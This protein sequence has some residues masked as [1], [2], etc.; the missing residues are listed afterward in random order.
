MSSMYERF[1]GVPP[2]GQSTSG[3]DAIEMF[4]IRPAAGHE[5]AALAAIAEHTASLGGVVL[6]STGGGGLVVGLPPGRKEA[7]AAHSLVGF[8]G[9]V[10]FAED[11]PG[12][13]L[14]RQRF[15]LNAAR[16][17]A[18]QGRTGVTDPIGR[19]ATNAAGGST[20]LPWSQRLA[21]PRTLLSSAGRAS[22]Q[23]PKGSTT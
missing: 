23:H 5:D 21:D 13:R 8:I 18:E 12:L 3:S 6:M 9:G 15:A 1:G 16:Q 7:L 14:L 20:E 10:S 19:G 4:F 17:L 22:S 2:A 11:A